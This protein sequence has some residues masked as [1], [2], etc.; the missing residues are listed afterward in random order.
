MKLSK[1]TKILIFIVMIELVA[2]ILF[3]NRRGFLFINWKIF[4]PKP[5]SI[6][7]I[8][9]YDFRKGI[10]FEIW[11][12]NSKKV[13]KIIK[14]KHFKPMNVEYVKDKM[15]K[16][17]ERVNEEQNKLLEE[18]LNMDDILVENNYYAYIQEN[19]DPKYMHFLILI[20]DV[21]TNKMYL[22]AYV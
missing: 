10:D 3:F 14:N 20:L 18:N 15:L 8:Y 19:D 11:N 22:F 16:Y 2:F 6:D 13:N 17:Y 12:Y 7:V 4:L 21:K 9:N 5:K 1:E